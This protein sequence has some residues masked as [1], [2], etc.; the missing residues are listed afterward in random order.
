[1]F[2]SFKK[3]KIFLNTFFSDTEW[4]ASLVHSSTSLIFLQWGVCLILSHVQ[5]KSSEICHTE[6]IDGQLKLDSLIEKTIYSNW[7]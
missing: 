7:P 3:V 5:K 6:W 1:M 2:V 4:P